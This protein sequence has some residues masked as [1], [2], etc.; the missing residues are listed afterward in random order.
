M[1]RNALG[2]TVPRVVGQSIVRVE[3]LPAPPRRGCYN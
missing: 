1:S 2:G 3:G